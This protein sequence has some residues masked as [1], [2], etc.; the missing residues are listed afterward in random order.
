MAGESSAYWVGWWTMRGRNMSCI[1]GEKPEQNHFGVFLREAEIQWRRHRDSISASCATELS[2]IEARGLEAGHNLQSWWETVSATLIV[3][4]QGRAERL[5]AE[6]KEGTTGEMG[7]LRNLYA[8]VVAR[9][10][11]KADTNWKGASTWAARVGKA[12]SDFAAAP[13]G[14]APT[15]VLPFDPGSNPFVNRPLRFA[16]NAMLG[17]L[18]KDGDGLPGVASANAGELEKILQEALA[19]GISPDQVELLA[20]AIAIGVHVRLSANNIPRVFHEFC[21]ELAA[22]STSAFAALDDLLGRPTPQGLKKATAWLNFCMWD[23]VQM[24]GG[25]LVPKGESKLDLGEFEAKDG[26][27]SW[28][29]AGAIASSEAAYHPA[30]IASLASE[31]LSKHLAFGGFQ[32][33]AAPVNETAPPRAKAPL[34]EL[35]AEPKGTRLEHSIRIGDEVVKAAPR[36]AKALESLDESGRAELDHRTVLGL[37]KMFPDLEEY[38]EKVAGSKVRNNKATYKAPDLKGRVKK[39]DRRV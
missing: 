16:L 14:A 37:I 20:A 5:M 4:A 34:I 8:L 12:I 1:N 31:A 27:S 15:S 21:M 36:F 33:L 11:W 26:L 17:V 28:F 7:A 30:M 13:V 35:V 23:W 19:G 6:V 32:P 24:S 18:G 29:S 10:S 38:I 22:S 9:P 39:R 3:D 2:T 25:K